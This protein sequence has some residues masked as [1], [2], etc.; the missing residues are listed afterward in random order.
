MK[1]KK[2][3]DKLGGT[4][5]VAQLMGVS[6]PAVYMW[7][8]KGIP[9]DKLIRLAPIAEQKG[10]ATRRDLRPNDWHLIWPELAQEA[11]EE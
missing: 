4:T 5:V 10:I 9:V 2:L 7:R 1:P 8:T 11:K 6:Y 3:I